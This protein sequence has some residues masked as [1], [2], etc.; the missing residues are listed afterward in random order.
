M[1]ETRPSESPSRPAPAREGRPRTPRVPRLLPA[2]GRADG[3][4]RPPRNAALLALAPA[5]A[6]RALPGRVERELGRWLRRVRRIDERV[7]HLAPAGRP[8]VGRALFS[9][10]I[11]P[12]VARRGRAIDHSHSHFWESWRMAHVL[13]ELGFEVDVTHWTNRTFVPEPVYDLLIDV[14]HNLERWAPRLGPDCLRVMHIETAHPS[15]YI[16]AQL[17]RLEALASRRGIRL[18]PFK[19]I[20]PNRAIEHADAA[21]ILGNASTQATY[22]FAGVPL[23]PVPISQ[24]LLYPFPERKRF[25]EV[26]RRFLWFGS[27]GMVH[28]GLDLVLD[29]FSGMPDYQLTVVGP[30]ERERSFERAYRRELYATP[31]IRTVGWFDVA[32]RSFLELADAHLGLVY[33]S[34][35]EGQSGGVVT[36]LHASLLPVVTPQV[37]VDVDPAFGVTLGETSIESIRAAVAELA[38]RPPAVLAAMAKRAW[39]FARARH[40]RERFESEYRAQLLAIFER[41][42][43][44]LRARIGA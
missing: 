44:A 35:S 26:R 18:R 1:P 15:F 33:P 39:E 19:L 27:G 2:P 24:P 12:F 42:R 16:P 17:A 14:R 41:F 43:P 4:A 22:A 30:V 32:E 37:G 36:C 21:T 38:A 10:I 34:C 13:V 23:Y 20:E 25:D 5:V 3:G 8:A 11:D 6:L 40:T 31:N 29:A 28:K 7:V 9:F